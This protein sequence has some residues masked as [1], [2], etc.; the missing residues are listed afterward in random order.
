VH[1]TLYAYTR[2]IKY[3]NLDF[4]I[5]YILTCVINIVTVAIVVCVDPSGRAV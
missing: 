1:D 4:F 2:I 3:H 5:H